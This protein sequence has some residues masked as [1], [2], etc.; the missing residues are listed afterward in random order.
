MQSCVV[1]TL[2]APLFVFFCKLWKLEILVFLSLSLTT[3]VFTRARNYKNLRNV[4]SKASSAYR[5]R[6]VYHN[7]NIR[8]SLTLLKGQ[9]YNKIISERDLRSLSF[10]YITFVYS[11]LILNNRRLMSVT[12]AIQYMEQNVLLITHNWLLKIKKFNIAHEFSEKITSER[13]RRYFFF[14]FLTLK[15]FYEHLS[16][17]SSNVLFVLGHS[18]EG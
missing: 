9:N 6:D 18:D 16:F 17:E 5:S 2:K 7:S 13:R 1:V 11:V 14:T 12:S 10:F 8:P 4:L 3:V 15:T